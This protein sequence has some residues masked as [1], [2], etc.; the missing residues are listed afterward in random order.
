LLLT[1]IID[2]SRRRGTGAVRGETMAGNLRMQRLAQD[3]GFELKT[4]ADSGTVELHLALRESAR[5]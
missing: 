1:R 4:G 2:Y 5:N 3:L